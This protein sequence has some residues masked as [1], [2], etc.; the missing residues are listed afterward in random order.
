[1]EGVVML[2][3]MQDVI[4]AAGGV[5]W[6]KNLEGEIEI[7]IIHRAAYDDWSLPKGK[8]EG[9]ESLFSCASREIEE[10]TGY[11][12]YLGP[13]LGDT[14]YTVE[15]IPKMVRYWAAQM[16]EMNGNGFDQSEVDICNWLSP[17]KAIKKLTM[18]DDRQIV[19]KFIKLRR[20]TKPLVLLRHAK[21]VDRR[22]WDGDD[23]DRPLTDKGVK[24]V[25]NLLQ[26]MK[27]F[28]ISE[29]HSSD[30]IRCLDTARPIAEALG[31]PLIISK[32]LSEYSYSRDEK[33]TSKYIK[34]LY[35]KNEAILICG[36]NPYLSKIV[37]KFARKLHMYKED[38]SLGKGD[39]FILHR[40][41]AKVLSIDH[42]DNL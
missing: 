12:N 8:A 36:H 17:E 31:L 15:G 33:M 2:R 25:A 24:Q 35:E 6:R 40:T 20:D 3:D 19:K 38:F 30:A 10:E 23:G 9:G 29:V 5:L 21:A 41:G 7:A 16:I 13:F 27:V 11:R 22:N 37:K 26:T 32:E 1:M 18:K 39:A 4:Q 28:G 14:F 34:S 42:I